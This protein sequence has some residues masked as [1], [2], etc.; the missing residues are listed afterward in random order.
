VLFGNALECIHAT[1]PWQLNVQKYQVN[2]WVLFQ[3]MPNADFVPGL[4]AFSLQVRL[5][6]NGFQSLTNQ[7]VIVNY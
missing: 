6:Q 4:K 1:E 5:A 3:T 7:A 2:V